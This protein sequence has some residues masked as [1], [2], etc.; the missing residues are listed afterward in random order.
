MPIED[1]DKKKDLENW[2]YL[3]KNIHIIE[4]IC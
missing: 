4:F 2:Y 1:Q 3:I